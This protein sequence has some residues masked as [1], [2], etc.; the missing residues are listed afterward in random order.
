MPQACSIT[1]QKSG[2]IQTNS[3]SHLSREK[4]FSSLCSNIFEVFIFQSE[5]IFCHFCGKLIQTQDVENH[6]LQSQAETHLI[7]ENVLLHQSRQTENCRNEVFS[8]HF[9]AETEI[10]VEIK[11]CRNCCEQTWPTKTRLHM[12]HYSIYYKEKWHPLLNSAGP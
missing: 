6:F 10:S 8:F 3:D 2:S 7:T 12:Y 1:V 9:S 4:G 5:S 11:C